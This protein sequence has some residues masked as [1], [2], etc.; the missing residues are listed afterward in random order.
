ME[1]SWLFSEERKRKRSSIHGIFNCLD[2]R[3]WCTWSNKFLDAR[4]A[5]NS[6]EKTGE[7]G[8]ESWKIY[9]PRE[10]G[11]DRTLAPLANHFLDQNNLILSLT[12]SIVFPSFHGRPMRR[13]GFGKTAP[14]IHFQSTK[15][16][17]CLGQN[18]VS[19]FF[20]TMIPFLLPLPRLIVTDIRFRE[21][22]IAP[23]ETGPSKNFGKSGATTTTNRRLNV[24]HQ[25]F[26]LRNPKRSLFA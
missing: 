26:P 5:G 19:L 3:K 2:S 24:F 12:L 9:A 7:S 17:G 20:L 11:R 23:V 18:R 22:F 25:D 16:L 13:C 15:R 1:V 8:K 4:V 21:I 10:G 14:P 6:G